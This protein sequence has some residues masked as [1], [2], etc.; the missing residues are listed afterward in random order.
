MRGIRYCNHPAYRTA[1]GVR[2]AAAHIIF[3]NRMTPKTRKRTGLACL[4]VV[5]ALIVLQ[6]Q[7]GFNLITTNLTFLLMAAGVMLL[8]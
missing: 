5:G 3:C 7:V 1:I 2:L 8:V 4:G 6:S